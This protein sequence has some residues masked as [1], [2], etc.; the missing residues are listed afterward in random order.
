MRPG[1]TYFES[2]R[3]FEA[4]E[5]ALR[6]VLAAEALLRRAAARL[7]EVDTPGCDC[8]GGVVYAL[9]KVW[10]LRDDLNMHIRI[11]QDEGGIR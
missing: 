2:R 7:E 5:L 10:N 4:V 1:Q 6:D 8:G 3:S 11:A 9:D